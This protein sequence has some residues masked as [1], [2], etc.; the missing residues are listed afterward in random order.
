MHNRWD[1]VVGITYRACRW[2]PRCRYPEGVKPAPTASVVR[3]LLTAGTGLA[4]VVV[5]SVALAA[6]ASAEPAEGWPATEPIDGLQALLLLGGIPVL[7]FVVIVVATYLPALVRGE[8]ITPGGS[9]VE[10]QWLGGRR[11]AGQ[12][13]APD[14]ETSAAGGASGRW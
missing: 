13:A 14:D 12:L 6:P 7:L 8:S 4:A 11:P 1:G 3:R 5:T 2:A 10:D 9:S